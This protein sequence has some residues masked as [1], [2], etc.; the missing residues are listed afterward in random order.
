M[1]QISSQIVS[2]KE[3]IRANLKRHKIEI[4]E[5]GQHH[6]R[7]AQLKY[8][9]KLRKGKAISHLGEQKIIAQVLKMRNQGKSYRQIASWLSSQNIP[10]KNRAG[11]WHPEMVRRLAVR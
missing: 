5:R 7:P 6:G 4:R 1:A 2:S 3:A 10:T 11:V 9:K 8:G